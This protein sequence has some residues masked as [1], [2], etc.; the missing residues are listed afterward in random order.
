[1]VTGLSSSTKWSRFWQSQTD[2][3][4]PR[5]DEIY[6]SRHGAEL[7]ALWHG[8]KIT[9]VL[10]L[11]C[12]S[13]E[14][15]VHLGFNFA[16][17]YRGVDISPSMLQQFRSRHPGVDLVEADCVTYRDQQTYDLVFSNQLVQY[18]DFGMFKKYLSNSERML[19]A[20]GLLVVASVPW[21]Q[22]RL[23]YW[24][25]RTIGQPYKGS[26][27]VIRTL[28]GVYLKGDP[29]GHWYDPQDVQAAA[30]EIG[31]QAEFFGSML[32]PYRFHTIFERSNHK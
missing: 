20:T 6:C 2:P 9:R 16:S 14:L 15:F 5:T 1:M 10:D 23:E 32:Y 28:A 25:G 29:L 27:Q 3:L 12:G 19:S 26:A 22:R 18:I 8:R 21:R 17:T 13:G 31:L 7:K 11:G 24:R 30:R 4:Y